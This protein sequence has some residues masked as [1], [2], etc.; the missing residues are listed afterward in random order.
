[1]SYISKTLKK[2]QELRQ[3]KLEH[4][5]G[6][7]VYLTDVPEAWPK[8]TLRLFLVVCIV[9]A[10][11]ISITIMIVTMRKFD[12]KQI[13]VTN[14]EKTI[15]VQ[16][17]RMNDLV[18]I[19][20]KNEKIRDVQINELNSRF[21][22]EHAT[23]KDLIDASVSSENV[24]Y[25]DLKG[26]ILDGKEDVNLLENEIKVLGQKIDAMSVA[27]APAKDVTSPVSGN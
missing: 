22:K 16:E 14:L 17:K 2:I 9:I 20:N 11:L 8:T 6:K 7:I 18:V 15:K 4:Q 13:E 10:I 21:T 12:S 23:T 3:N 19:I 5:P 27:S 1:M 24:H 26:A 25:S